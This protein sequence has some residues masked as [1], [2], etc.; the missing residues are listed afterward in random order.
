MTV[1]SLPF[2]LTFTKFCE[3]FTLTYNLGRTYSVLIPVIIKFC[4]IKPLARQNK[5]NANVAKYARR[6]N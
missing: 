6:V 1:Q 2:V 3:H 5:S 4:T